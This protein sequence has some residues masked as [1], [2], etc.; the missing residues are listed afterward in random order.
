MRV[1]GALEAEMRRPTDLVARYGG[2]EFAVLL[3]DTDETGARF[4]AGRLRKTIEA[5]AIVIR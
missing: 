5:L 4:V 3:P 1:A 2:D